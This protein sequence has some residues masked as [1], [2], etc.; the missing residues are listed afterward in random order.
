M[1][2][3]HSEKGVTG[4]ELLAAIAVL[5]VAAAVILW[6]MYFYRSYKNGQQA[7]CLTRLD[8]VRSVVTDW[9]KTTSPANPTGDRP[10]C[11]TAKDM[12]EKYNKQCGE[13]IG[14]LPVPTCE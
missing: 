6:G 4:L 1:R 8:T 3:L 12:V 9:A 2:N 10:L 7:V 5:V 14:K 13:L 11:T